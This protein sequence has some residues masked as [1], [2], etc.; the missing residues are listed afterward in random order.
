M[1]QAVNKWTSTT[2]G[3]TVAPMKS[4]DYSQRLFINI[5]DGPQSVLFVAE[6]P[7]GGMGERHLRQFKRHE[8]AYSALTPETMHGHRTTPESFARATGASRA[9]SLRRVTRK[10]GRTPDGRRFDSEFRQ[11]TAA[12]LAPD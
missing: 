12:L 11:P 8:F 5:G 4:S 2:P 7:Q 3:S 1:R 10:S 6:F 9:P